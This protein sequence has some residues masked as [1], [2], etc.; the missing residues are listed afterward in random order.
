MTKQCPTCG[1]DYSPEKQAKGS[2]DK[3][4]RCYKAEADEVKEAMHD[5]AVLYGEAR[6]DPGDW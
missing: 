5:A 1:S 3:C 2:Q 6:P 4:Y